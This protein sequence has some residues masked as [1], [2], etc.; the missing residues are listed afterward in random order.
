M[1]EPDL[2]ASRSESKSQV[3]ND[4]INNSLIDLVYN[5]ER[6]KHCKLEN[7]LKNQSTSNIWG[8]LG[9]NEI[10]ALLCNLCQQ[11]AMGISPLI[12]IRGLLMNYY[13]SDHLYDRSPL[14]LLLGYLKYYSKDMKTYARRQESDLWLSSIATG[15]LSNKGQYTWPP[16]RITFYKVH[17]TPK[18]QFHNVL[19]TFKISSDLNGWA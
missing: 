2:S 6:R 16:T 12:M 19:I 15:K 9:C 7:T 13:P 1:A 8:C 17:P 4:N 18:S 3:H 11:E 5:E 10:L 14:S